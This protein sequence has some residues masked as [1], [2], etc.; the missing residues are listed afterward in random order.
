MVDAMQ[1]RQMAERLAKAEQLVAA[2]KVHTISGLDGYYAVESST[3]AAYYLVHLKSDG[4]CCSCPDWAHHGKET[5]SACK[6]IFGAQLVAVA[7]KPTEPKAK[8]VAPREDARPKTNGAAL[9]R[10]QGDTE[11]AYPMRAA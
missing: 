7:P 11:D 6:H 1:V 4:A 3:G 10:L 9:V 2:G 5:D 8:T